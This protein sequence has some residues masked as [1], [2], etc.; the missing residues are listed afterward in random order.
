M[1][2][3]AAEYNADFVALMWGP[4]GLPRDENERA[5]CA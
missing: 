1:V 4:E 2:P 3:M 5:A